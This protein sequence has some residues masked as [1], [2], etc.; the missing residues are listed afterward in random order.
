MTKI[1]NRI[2]KTEIKIKKENTIN[3]SNND[4]EI[5][6][7]ESSYAVLSSFFQDFLKN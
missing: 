3:M 7:D 6:L 4:T 5:T 2:T 1:H